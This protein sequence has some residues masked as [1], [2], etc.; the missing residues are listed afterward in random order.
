MFAAQQHKQIERPLVPEQAVHG[1]CH[2]GA[3]VGQERE[4]FTVPARVDLD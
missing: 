3:P 2:L 1:P 4:G